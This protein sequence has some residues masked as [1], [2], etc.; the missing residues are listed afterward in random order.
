MIQADPTWVQDSGQSQW[1]ESVEERMPARR[2]E[3][4]AAYSIER[5]TRK[6]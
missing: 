6:E 5:H 2:L 1:R 4:I 3:Q